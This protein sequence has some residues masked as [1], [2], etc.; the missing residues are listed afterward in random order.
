MW[1]LVAQTVSGV[2][3]VFWAP[4]WG[5]TIRF[6]SDVAPVLLA[7]RGKHAAEACSLWYVIQNRTSRHFLDWLHEH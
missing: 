5:E 4:C 7:A 3:R 1:V 2:D 6:L